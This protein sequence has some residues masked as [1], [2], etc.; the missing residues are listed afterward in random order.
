MSRAGPAPSRRVQAYAYTAVTTAVVL[1]FAVA[2]WATERFLSDRSRAASTA[3]ELFIV[4]VATLVFRPIHRKTEALLEAAFYKRRRQALAAL[5]KF[6]RELHSFK[7]MEQLLRRVVEA[8][9]HHLEARASAVYLRRDAF[10]PEASSFDVQAE[11]VPFDDPLAIRLR[12]SAAPARPPLLKS[13]ACGTHAF[14]MTVAGDLAG[15]LTMQCPHGEYDSEESNMLVGLAQDLGAAVVALD[16]RLRSSKRRAPNNIPAHLTALVGREREL[17]EIKAA[18]AQSR[19][20]TL[21]G[22]GGVGKT[23]L[24]LQ[25]AAEEIDAHHDGAWFVSLSP[26]TDPALVPVTMLAALEAGSSEQEDEAARLIE[27]LRVRD[28]LV[29]IDNCEQVLAAVTPLVARIRA[30]CPQVRILAT[31]RELLHLDGEQVYR[32][33]ALRSD[34]AVELFAKRA[35][36]VSPS[37]EPQLHL[38]TIGSIC[39]HLDGIPLAIELAAARVRALSVDDILARLSERFRLLTGGSRTAEPRQQTLVR[40]I[41]WSY[42][43]LPQE[44]QSLFWHLAAFR[45]SFTLAGAAAVCAQDGRCDEFHVLDLLTS[46]ADKS[47]VGVTLGI[48]T[49]YRLLESIREFAVQKVAEHQATEIVARQHASYFAQLAAQ[50][51]HEF[52]THLPHGWLDRLAPDIDNFRA[53]LEWTLVNQGD[54]LTGAQLAADCGPVF[55]RLELLAEGL[56]WSAAA[57]RVFGTSTAISGRIEYVASMMHNNLGEYNR[58][59][60]CAERA[61]AFY[62]RSSD[63]RGLIRSLAQVAQLCGRLHRYHEAIP[64]ADEALDRARA[65]GEPRILVG[66]LRR[67]AHSLPPDRIHHARELFAEA[68]KVAR[69]VSDSEEPSLILQWWA[70]REAAAGCYHRAIELA[71]ISLESAAGHWRMYLESQIACY[72][73]ASGDIDGAAENARAA[74]KLSLE[75]QHP[76]FTALSIAYCSAFAAQHDAQSAAILLGYATARLRE[77]EWRGEADDQLALANVSSEISR[78]LSPEIF[79][80]STARGRALTQQAVLDIINADFSMRPTVQN[81]D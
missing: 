64:P 12:S 4:L 81:S 37:F 9:D 76:L 75:A 72:T 79:E 20:V 55:L 66:V 21:T 51:Y 33:G 25:C 69:S 48:S 31:S 77:L 3:V 45:G 15:F 62:K 61:V 36:S 68:L 19:L 57:R 1:L 44:E 16:P 73:L 10:R 47:L 11:S 35:A 14:A 78:S 22:A 59:L 56:H 34:A 53:A 6:R 71:K 30:Q 74:L 18:L 42:D 58:A 24:A 63:Q 17:A 5:E 39:D 7:D 49:R 80:A 40:A 52:D 41:E 70:V 13:R 2:E 32:L 23:S 46:L 54:R 65:L 27:H 29:V 43:L 28:A 38:Q 26:I 50:A 60:M 67:C 8:V